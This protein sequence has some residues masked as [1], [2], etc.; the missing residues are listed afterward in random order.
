M[1]NTPLGMFSIFAGGTALVAGVT[2]S[3]FHSIVQGKPDHSRKKELPSGESSPT[4]SQSFTI[5]GGASK[6]RSVLERAKTL[7]GTPYVWGGSEPGG[8]DCSGLVQYVY[9]LKGI[10]L[11]RVAQE[12]YNAT[13]KLHRNEPPRPGD[14]AFFSSTGSANNITHVGIYLGGSKLLDAPHTGA[15]VRVEGFNPSVGSSYGEDKLI[16][17][18]EP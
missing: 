7:I 4:V 13:R 18:T 1:P 6:F 8:F 5:S 12:Q 10:H 17:Y 9:G 3:S 16:G 14:L 15:D 11:P 2:G